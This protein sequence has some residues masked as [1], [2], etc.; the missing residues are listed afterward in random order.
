MKSWNRFSAVWAATLL[1]F[2]M[3]AAA[4]SRA[5]DIEMLQDAQH[6]RGRQSLDIWTASSVT[7][8][9]VD[10][11]DSGQ[12]VGISGNDTISGPIPLGISFRWF[13]TTQSAIR[14]CTNG[15]LTFNSTAST[16]VNTAIP[17]A[18]QPN[19]AFYVFWDDLMVDDAQGDWIK[20]LADTTNHRFIVTWH[21]RRLGG[22]LPVNL[23]A[24]MVPEGRITY[25]YQTLDARNS[26]TVGM[27][28]SL[29]SYGL[30]MCFDG[31]GTM[32]NASTAY[33]FQEAAGTPNPV[34]DLAATTVGTNVVLT[35]TNTTTDIYGTT[36]IVDSCDVYQ[37]TTFVARVGAGVTTYAHANTAL[38]S[39]NYTVYAWNQN[40]SSLPTSVAVNV[41]A[42]VYNYQEDFEL[43]NGGWAATPSTGGW[44]WGVP[45]A[46]NGPTAHS[47][48]KLW[49]TVLAGNYVDFACYQLQLAAAQSVASADAGL[50][51]WGWYKSE[52]GA[53]TTYDGCNFQ[54][55]TNGG[56][57]WQILTPLIGAYDDTFMTALN[58][59]I[60]FHKPTW[61]GS[62]AADSLVTG[63]WRYFVLPLSNFVGLTPVFRF[64]FGS[65]NQAHNYP[66]FYFDDLSVWGLQ[67]GSGA[68]VS[69][70]I[71]LDGGSGVVTQA[72]V[73]A[74]GFGGPP[75]SPNALG[76]YSLPNVQLGQR[77]LFATL[78]GYQQAT[79]NVAVSGDIS[80]A[81]LTVRREAPPA[82]TALTAGLDPGTGIVSLDWADSPDLLV[83]LYRVY[84]KRSSDSSYVL[85]RVVYSRTVSSATDT[86]T[87][88]AT[89]QYVVTAVDTNVI[90]P[91]IE[92][93]CSNRAD[94]TYGA[95]PPKSLH[96][97][98]DFDD[99]VR[100]TWVGPTDPPMVEMHYD[101]GICSPQVS[102]IGFSAQPLFGWVA[103][104]FQTTGPVTVYRLRIYFTG[105]ALAGTAFQVGLFADNG[106]GRPT[107]T[108]LDVMNAIVSPPLDSFRDF[109]LTTPRT[110]S[111]GIF[112]VGARQLGDWS[113]SIGGDMQTPFVN[114][115]FFFAS[116]PWLWSTFEPTVMAIPMMRA[117]VQ[118]TAAQEVALNPSAE[119]EAVRI[120]RTRS[121]AHGAPSAELIYGDARFL[122]AVGSMTAS[123]LSNAT[124]PRP[125]HEEA[126][127]LGS[128]ARF[129]LDDLDYYIVYRNGM[130]VAHPTGL[131][132]DDYV[133]EGTTYTYWLTSHYSGGLES[134]HSDTVAARPAMAPGAPVVN[135]VGQANNSM[136][137]TWTNPTLNADGTPCV[138]LD[139]LRIYRGGTLL[140]TVASAV[141]QYVD[142]P[143]YLH[144]LYTWSVYGV[145]EAMNVGPAGVFIGSVLEP[146]A[147]VSFDWV[148][149]STSGASAVTGNDVT[150]AAIP[151]GFMFPFYGSYYSQVRICTNGWLSFLT[152]SSSSGVN[153]TLPST[154]EPNAAIYPFWDDLNVVAASG[155]WVKYRAD[156]GR[157]VI[158]WYCQLYSGGTG[159]FEFQVILEANG[160]ITMH[161][162]STPSVMNS[163]TLGV[164]NATGTSALML[165]YNGAGSWAPMMG[166][167]IQIF[168]AVPVYARATGNVA[169]D[170]GNGTMTSVTVSA[171]GLNFPF[172]HPLTDGSWQMDSVAVGYRQ[173][174]ARLTGF[175][176]DTL[177]ALVPASGVANLNFT[178]RR[179]NPSA[180]TG[181]VATIATAT[182]I[183]TMDWTDSPDPLVDGYR[184][185]RKPAA[186]STWT[187]VKT[188]YGRTNSAA[189]DTLVG[190]MGAYNF[191]V[192]AI[193]TNV[194]GSP[195]ESDRSASSTIIA[196]HPAPLTLAAAG[197]F[198]DRI[199]LTWQAPG[200][201]L[202][203]SGLGGDDPAASDPR[204]TAQAYKSS[205]AKESRQVAWQTSLPR[206]HGRSL[207]EVT[208]YRVYRDSTL[209]ATV[210]GNVLRY[211]D[212]NLPENQP[213]SYAVAALY[214]DGSES[215][216]SNVVSDVRCNLAPG[217][218][219]N[220]TL[221]V[222]GVTMRLRWT[223]PAVNAL[224][225]DGAATPCADL[226]RIRVYRDGVLIDSVAPGVNQ[227]T[228]TPS[229]VVWAHTW[230]LRAADEVPNISA[231][232][233]KFGLEVTYD[234][235]DISTTG[236]TIGFS[237]T[238]DGNAG[239]F[240]LG[241]NFT[242]YGQIYNSVRVCTNGWLTFSNSTSTV[243]TNTQIPNTADPNAALYLFWDDLSIESGWVKYL[244]DPT[245][246]RFIVTWFAARLGSSVYA[247]M[248]IILGSHGS[249]RFQYQS[250]PSPITSCTIGLENA[251][252]T[253]GI[254][255][256]FD[257]S[258]PLWM[259]I[260]QSAVEFWSG[261][262][263]SIEG[264][265]ATFSGGIPLPGCAVWADNAEGSSDTVLTDSIGHY[266]LRLEPGTYTLHFDHPNYCPVTMDAVIEA[267]V[268][269]T[270][271]M[272]LRTPNA[273]FSVSS[274]TFV[275]PSGLSDDTTFIIRNLG[276][277][278]CPLSY[279]ISDTSSWLSV[280]PDTGYLNP[281]RTDTIHVYVDAAGVP[282]NSELNST[283]T[284]NYHGTGSP[285][286]IRV[287]V[288][289]IPSA[290]GDLVHSL[291]TEFALH[292]S[293]PN[294][295][296]AQTRL[297]FDVPKESR[298][299]ILIYNIMGQEVAHPVSSIYQPGRYGVIFDAAG[300]P[301]G[302]YLLKMTA[303][304]FT[305]IGKMML[306]K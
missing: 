82:P 191:A 265:V 153:T 264:T 185:Y 222:L 119:D 121:G 188:V 55:S 231:A 60:G 259:P 283:L 128:R 195:V 257:T 110:F 27:E 67:T 116:D 111:N 101:N 108:A 31:T 86:L 157:F 293:Y 97:R 150:S 126:V 300:L 133:S 183:V 140:G 223:D 203:Q 227:Y 100:L 160:T 218:P 304:D 207:D 22:T 236:T 258:T 132:Y 112:Y 234:W 232:I 33:G 200:T 275:I 53:T 13:G 35:W 105:N 1:V 221:T 215:A 291:P 199:R 263:G 78:T 39:L 249:V 175:I 273:Q 212:R 106:S 286:S 209:L 210:A 299:D 167:A 145:D 163:Y 228:D 120:G 235:A 288:S 252:G 243:Y 295:F 49:G 23:Q 238:D 125:P 146:W 161:Y 272:R 266:L 261:P 282:A 292:Q 2:V 201:S 169:F 277:G 281:N 186:S 138:D 158:D 45:T 8:T 80:N 255:L 58:T 244:S 170:G 179:N 30:Q 270:Q 122:S 162:F 204:G 96:A 12:S 90:A 11:S 142:F 268:P 219:T 302:M 305:H 129:T 230:S 93:P 26:C 113:L 130:D 56:G 63:R 192:T 136:L 141:T 66:G 247:Q 102:G 71:T 28:D 50:A 61:N 242:Y 37:G 290:A 187:F 99:H 276:S 208:S 18:A 260:E 262:A 267:N 165:C 198:D 178:L 240:S 52:G 271:D 220:F 151:L 114:N 5:A 95:L 62:R 104:R 137:I 72:L 176:S 246:G 194:S 149:I 216:W 217:V 214:D 190:L 4:A 43:S 81:N 173:F 54:I 229:G 143:R 17:S 166:S 251:T 287:D 59:C 21:C 237:S 44:E 297:R 224:N 254:Q 69:G 289:V 16:G 148:D 278:Q 245:N 301:S 84:R 24:I 152:T 279:A 7:Y 41:S 164:E 156:P 180:P 115:T 177:S 144:V 65:D 124:G 256:M 73:R 36:I 159:P 3:S 211:E 83:D 47:G 202:M 225:A 184:V 40:L 64:T 68:T 88:T 296:N 274:L 206:G 303:G 70:M 19:G 196:G 241:F 131:S 280:V 253:E 189:T 38:G 6:E 250:L 94:V 226:V 57:T 248:Q 76:T 91:A 135:G 147:D 75:V 9:W 79:L 74:N 117:V 154:S 172:T 15:F 51:F 92:S 182:Q 46:A 87:A 155:Q 34:T 20:Y 127:T 25:Q 171:S 298:V 32:P 29:G 139:S 213:H 77:I 118:G 107:F 181:F 294:P 193:D 134:S 14:V 285:H 269:V 306:L 284:I 89:Y 174:I 103:A 197:R 205:A 123:R 233:S 98:T 42:P 10:I 48:T 168:A 109:Y 239:P 85:Q